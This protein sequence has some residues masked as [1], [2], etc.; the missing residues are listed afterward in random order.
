MHTTWHIG[1]FVFTIWTKI[2]MI[3]CCA[4]CLPS[5]PK[6][7]TGAEGADWVAELPAPSLLRARYTHIRLRS[8]IPRFACLRV[9]GC[10]KY[11]EGVNWRG[12]G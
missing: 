12:L 4:K 2:R 3:H 9:C 11:V 8:V 5:G 6:A 1:M 10:S 7:G